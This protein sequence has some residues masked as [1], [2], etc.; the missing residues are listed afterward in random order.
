MSLS[1]HVMRPLSWDLGAQP[2][3]AWTGGTGGQLP[4]ACTARGWCDG[5]LSEEYG[6]PGCCLSLAHGAMCPLG[7]EAPCAAEALAPVNAVPCALV[8][9]P[10]AGVAQDL[11]RRELHAHEHKPWGFTEPHRAEIGKADAEAVPWGLGAETRVQT[12]LKR[13][14]SVSGDV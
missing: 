3:A 1:P 4:S 8:P 11:S 13:E 9:E 6:W 5:S 7:T 2:P 14:A 12:C 10:G